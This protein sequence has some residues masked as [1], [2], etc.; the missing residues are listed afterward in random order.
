VAH[1][2]FVWEPF[3]AGRIATIRWSAGVTITEDIAR[4]TIVQQML[5]TSGKR[6]PVLADIR[7][8]RSMT[9]GARMFYGNATSSFSALGLLAGSPATR[10]TANFFIGFNRPKVPTK[11]FTDEA[12]ALTWLRGYAG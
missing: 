2:Q 4:E 9:R 5:L 8:L 1:E 3:G 11:L 10:V 7:Q 6:V 12:A